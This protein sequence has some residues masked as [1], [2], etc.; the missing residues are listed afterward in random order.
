VAQLLW[1][2]H[3]EVVDSLVLCATATSFGARQQLAGPVGRL[4]LGASMALSLVPAAVRQRGM[5]LATRNRAASAAAADWA[6]EEWSLCDPSALIQAGLALGRFDSSPWIGEIDVPT[7][8]V[9]TARDQ[10]VAPSRQWAMTRSIRGAVAFPV[11]GDHRVC[12]DEP[13]RFIPALLSA[14]RAVRRDAA[15]AA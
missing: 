4:G 15:P 10:M 2:R 14:C 9:V 1:H 12:V 5:N 11:P 7:S 13:E 8:V 3:R 6:I